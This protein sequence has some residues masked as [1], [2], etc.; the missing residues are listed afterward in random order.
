MSRILVVDDELS[1][2]ELLEIFFLKEGHTVKVCSDGTEGVNILHEEEFDLVIT[3]LRMPGAHGMVVLQRCRELYPDTPIIVM[4]AYASTETAIAAMKMGAFDYFSKPFQ[5]EE[6]K[7]VIEKALERRHLVR[8]NRALRAELDQRGRLGGLIGKS[9]AM[10][11]V[12][13]LIRRVACT[14]TNVLILGA[15]GTGKELVARA[16]HDQ[17]DRRSRPFMVINCAAI[18]ENL[19]ESE[20][21]GHKRGAFTGATSD[22][23]GMFQGAD[24]GTL[25]LDEIGDMPLGMQAKLLRVLQERKVKRVG[26]LREVPVDVRVIAATNSDLES[27]VKAGN[28][29]EDLYYRLNVIGIDLPPLKDRTS[30]IPLLAHHFL[31]KYAQEF[32]KKIETIEPEVIQRF[33]RHPFDGNVRELENMMER[34]V[35]LEDGSS[36]TL[37][38][39]PPGL[40]ETHH[41]ISFSDAGITLPPGGLNLDG[42]VHQVERHLIE[43]ALQR[44]GGRKKD[45]AGLLGIT[46]RSFRYRLEKLGIDR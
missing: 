44:T 5:L 6:V 19:L 17:S 26:D 27:Q 40:R 41:E 3:D 7:V 15:S 28:F 34:A 18:P 30:D 25:L 13:S 43:Q 24:G 22:H 35:A 46:F 9:H 8:E 2:R 21:F 29:R 33:L 11:T 10:K 38:S 1:M 23:E 16:I 31:S 32:A 12:F 39:L 14:R 45:A 20:L 42:V 36:I 37:Q 4:T